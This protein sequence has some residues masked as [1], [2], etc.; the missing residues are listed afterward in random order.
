LNNSPKAEPGVQQDVSKGLF[1]NIHEEGC[2]D[3][4]NGGHSPKPLFDGRRENGWPRDEVNCAKKNYHANRDQQRGLVRRKVLT[5]GQRLVPWRVEGRQMTEIIIGK[6][7]LDGHIFDMCRNSADN[8]N[9]E[10]TK[11]FGGIIGG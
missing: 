1:V 2:A 9:D 4:Q 5:M 10:T 7:R 3:N 6:L 11:M 8:G